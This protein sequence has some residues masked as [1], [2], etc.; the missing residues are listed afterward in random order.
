MK[1]SKHSKIHQWRKK[2]WTEGGVCRKCGD[3]RNLTVEH[4]IPIVWI[5]GFCLPVEITISGGAYPVAISNIAVEWEDNF[6]VLCMMCNREKGGTIDP[7]HP[8]TWKLLRE[9]LNK[10]EKYHCEKEFSPQLT[11]LS[12]D[13]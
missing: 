5:T 13:A 8:K 4:I 2:L 9:L 6:E 3:K 12:T 10:A 7:R 11:P 1:G